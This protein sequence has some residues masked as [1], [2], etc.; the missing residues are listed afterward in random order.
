MSTRSF[1]V[2]WLERHHIAVTG[3]SKLV[4]H[5]EFGEQ[6]EYGSTWTV[7]FT[8]D[9]KYWQ[10]TYQKPTGQA[11]VDTWFGDLNITA[12]E[13]RPQPKF[14]TEWVPVRPNHSGRCKEPIA[15]APGDTVISTCDM[16]APFLLALAKGNSTASLERCVPHALMI[17]TSPETFPLIEE[18]RRRWH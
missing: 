4:V 14:V 9:G 16:D 11:Y 15:S 17:L 1:P 2:E 3:M 10:V 12:T 13:V 18:V 7:V 8:D 5:R 6:Q